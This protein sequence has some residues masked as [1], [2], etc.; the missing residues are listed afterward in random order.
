VARLPGLTAVCLLALALGAVPAGADDPRPNV[1]VIMTDDQTVADLRSMGS[2]R[3]LLANEGVSFRRSFV[4][5][6]L[7]CPS[8]ATFL[9]GQYAHNHRV[10]GL[11]PPTGGYRRFDKRESLPVWLQRAGYRTAHVGKYLNGYGTAVPAT[12]PPGWTE[13]YGAVDPSAYRMWGY[14]LNENGLLRTYGHAL[15][16][17]EAALYQTDL[18]RDRAVDVIGRGRREGRPFFLS[19]A[20]L[21][22]HHETSGVRDV[23]EVAVRAAPRHRGL[24]AGA[25]LP[26]PRSFDE[27]DVSDK[28]G[29][30]RRR[31][32]LDSFEE[33][34]IVARYRQRRES[35]YAVDEAVEAIV[36]Q[37]A[38]SGELDRTYLL[39]TSD[40]G[41]MQGEH[42][43]PS[44]K[45][46]PYEPST[47]VPLLLR[48]PGL[49]RGRGSSELVGNVDLAPTILQLARA[50]AG[51]PVDGRSLLRF[52]RHP[53]RRSRRALLHETGGRRFVSG[54]ELDAGALPT[55]RRV[56]SWRAVRTR[57]WLWVEYRGGARELYDLL[58]DP[59]QLRSRHADPRYHGTRKALRRELRRLVRCRGSRCRAAAGRIPGPVAR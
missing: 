47:R 7:C 1:V 10:L 25:R 37:L 21:A 3:R 53:G 6:P 17:E 45:M 51:K 28:P 14:S 36:D 8:R 54:G 50:P 13:W 12:V 31:Y 23:A 16:D 56:F 35:L 59:Q 26:R 24:A 9:S 34:E 58:R 55:V 49:P 30:I 19:V 29:Y 43:V 15:F 39:F 52:A 2:T 4:S 57:R 11:Y 5:Y 20:F 40:N 32:R 46:L 33:A 44:G 22:P 48:G 27:R 41:F 38:R 42:R 18:L